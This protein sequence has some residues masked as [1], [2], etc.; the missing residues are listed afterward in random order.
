M[1]KVTAYLALDGSVHL[2]ELE[3]VKRDFAISIRGKLQSGAPGLRTD[4]MPI[5]EICDAVVRNRDEI[6]TII[7]TYNRKIRGIES[8]KPKA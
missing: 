2:N 3:Q 8:R 5:K 6:Q 4:M 1:P 7:A